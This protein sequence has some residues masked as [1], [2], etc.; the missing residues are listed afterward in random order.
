MTTVP[1]FIAHNG[2]VRTQRLERMAEH[3]PGALVA[4]HKKDVVISARLDEAPG[5]VAI[6]GW[7][8]IGGVPIQPLYLGHGVSWVDYSHGV[9]LVHQAMRVNGSTTTVAGVLS[10]PCLSGLFSDEGVV[11]Q[12]RYATDRFQPSGPGECRAPADG[13]PRSCSSLQRHRRAARWEAVCECRGR[14]MW[15]QPGNA[16]GSERV[17]RVQQPDQRRRSSNALGAGRARPVLAQ[18][19]AGT[20]SPSHRPGRAQRFPSCPGGRDVGDRKSVV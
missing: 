14:D 17:V 5:K 3:P 20:Q 6:Y 8:R 12:P 2:I 13:R 18:G 7:H 1:V 4:G 15:T 11:A 19:K 16:D 9:R 10:D